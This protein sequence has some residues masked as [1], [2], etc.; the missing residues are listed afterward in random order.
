MGPAERLERIEEVGAE[1]FFFVVRGQEDL[2]VGE[3]W[4][5]VRN[6]G[7]SGHVPRV[8]QTFGGVGRGRAHC[9]NRIGSRD[10][11]SRRSQKSEAVGQRAEW[12][13]RPEAEQ[14]RR[15]SWPS[16]GGGGKF[17]RSIQVRVGRNPPNVM[18][19]RALGRIPESPLRRLGDYPLSC[20]RSCPDGCM[21]HRLD[22]SIAHSP[23]GNL[24][25]SSPES[26][27]WS[28]PRYSVP[29]DLGCA[30]RCSARCPRSR[31]DRCGL[32]CCPRCSRDSSENR[33]PSCPWSCS[34]SCSPGRRDNPCRRANVHLRD[35]RL[36]LSDLGGYLIRSG[37]VGSRLAAGG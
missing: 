2:A 17:S 13:R 36:V 31:S 33:F 34:V 37:V 27:L 3:A 25:R 1:L 14:R 28:L 5:T 29:R 4:D 19:N 22:G 12:C 24:D 23:E 16:A 7:H 11:K 8:N 21:V 10:R 20:L 15:Q 9:G 6:V 35:W 30:L 18:K 26:L 32:S